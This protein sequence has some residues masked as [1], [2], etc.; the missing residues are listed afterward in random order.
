MIKITTEG[1]IPADEKTKLKAFV[2]QNMIN[3]SQLAER[4]GYTRSYLS[5]V[6]NGSYYISNAFR[7]NLREALGEDSPL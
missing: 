2:S 6:V 3:L 1:V 4:M 5:M 7:K